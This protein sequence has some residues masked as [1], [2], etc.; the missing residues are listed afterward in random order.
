MLAAERIFNTLLAP[1]YQDLAIECRLQSPDQGM[2]G[3]AVKSHA[4]TCMS[5]LMV[6]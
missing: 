5:L 2:E 1:V 6:V 4:R 3:G